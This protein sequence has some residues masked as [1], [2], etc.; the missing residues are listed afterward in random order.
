[1]VFLLDATVLEILKL[2]ELLLVRTVELR[3]GLKA[4]SSLPYTVDLDIAALR[5]T[6]ESSSDRQLCHVVS[7]GF[8]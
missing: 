1:M 8:L 7:M 2:T 5:V 4:Q 3:M 6:K